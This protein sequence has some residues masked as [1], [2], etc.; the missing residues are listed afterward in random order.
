[1]DILLLDK[2]LVYTSTVLVYE[3]ARKKNDILCRTP[4]Q[5]YP[6]G[7]SYSSINNSMRAEESSRDTSALQ[8][9]AA[10]NLMHLLNIKISSMLREFTI[11][12][13]PSCTSKPWYTDARQTEGI[14]CAR[15]STV[16]ELALSS[17]LLVSYSMRTADGS[18]VSPDYRRSSSGR[19]HMHA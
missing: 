13:S 16:H 12:A 3:Y 2:H 10:R 5:Q 4:Q 7:E 8:Q 15:G 18:E 6:V 1:M 14:T 17:V 9:K 11:Y 19:N